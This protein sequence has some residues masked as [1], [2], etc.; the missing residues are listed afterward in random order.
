MASNAPTCLGPN[1]LPDFAALPDIPRNITTYLRPNTNMTLLAMTQC[2]APNPVHKTQHDCYLWCEVPDSGGLT[3]DKAQAA[4]Q[5]LSSCVNRPGLDTS[6]SGWQ[7]ASSGGGAGVRN[8]RLGSVVALSL[9]ASALV[10]GL[11]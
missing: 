3:G 8:M 7:I 1:G 6:I 5:S 9:V 11:L 2:C 10:S 4:A